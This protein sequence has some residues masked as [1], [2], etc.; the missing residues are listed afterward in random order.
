MLR[1]LYPKIGLPWAVRSLALLLLVLLGVANILLRA[2]GTNSGA[3]KRRSL[4]D[5]TALRDWPYLLFVAGCFVVF[6]GL[7]TPFVY[8]GSYALDEDIV[9]SNFAL[10]ILA[11]LNASSIFGRILPAFVA[12]RIG[13]MNMIIGTTVV[14]SITSICLLTAKTSAR[15]MA[16]IVFQG[17][18][19]GT[20]FALQPTIFV[21]LATDPSKIGTRFGMAF[22]V[23]SVALLFGSPISGALRKQMGYGA[24]W[25]WAAVTIL[26]GGGLIFIA[27]SLKGR[28]RKPL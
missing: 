16:A 2:R 9:S 10:Y 28:W 20:F 24:A 8:I 21:R 1:E 5:T 18:F 27:R 7:Y 14:L 22:S 12:Q 13:P 3:G 11:I 6:L 25:V 19:T 17:F 15:L 26:C 4:I 23:M